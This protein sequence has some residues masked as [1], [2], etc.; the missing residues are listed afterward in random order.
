[1]RTLVAIVLVA[2]CAAST[3]P[4]TTSNVAPPT[5]IAKIAAPAVP[6]TSVRAASSDDETIYAGLDT[7]WQAGKAP[8]LDPYLNQL[9]VDL[10][11]NLRIP[12]TTDEEVQPVACVHITPAGIVAEAKLETS[13]GDAALDESVEQAL[14]A[15]KFNRNEHAMPLPKRLLA[16]SKRWMCFRVAL[17]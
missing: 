3:P 7:E 16:S 14:E 2:G 9:V 5:P 10:R 8:P 4:A 13:S 17:D 6:R 12:P 15:V 11:Q 1:M